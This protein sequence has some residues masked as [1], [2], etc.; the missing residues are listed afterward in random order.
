MYILAL[1][2]SCFHMFGLKE[3]FKKTSKKKRA[4]QK[5]GSKVRDM[6]LYKTR[7][8]KLGKQGF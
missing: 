1:R 3:S 5:L 6:G 7:G 2:G 4:V 8:S